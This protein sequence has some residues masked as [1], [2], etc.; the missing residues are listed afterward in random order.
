MLN[1]QLQ[2]PVVTMG[3]KQKLE[4]E[5]QNIQIAEQEIRNNNFKH[6]DVE[7]NAEVTQQTKRAEQLKNILE[8]VELLPEQHRIFFSD[9]IAENLDVTNRETMVD[10][11]KKLPE[12]QAMQQQET[13]DHEIQMQQQQQQ[14]QMQMQAQA[15]QNKQP[16]QQ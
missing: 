10:R 8:F 5:S 9:I 16:E 15:Q 13:R 1:S 7:I 3:Q 4:E 14:A 11:A 2:D 12:I 6:Y